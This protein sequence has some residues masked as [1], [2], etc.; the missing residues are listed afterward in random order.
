MMAAVGF[1]AAGAAHAQTMTAGFYSSTGTV[2]SNNGNSNCS[3]IGLVPG[4]ANDSVL[5]FPGD[6]N[7]GLTIYVPLSG[8]E[9]LCNSF[10]NV[11]SGG[12]NN[13]NATS[14]CV[15]YTANGAIPTAGVQFSFTSI[16]VDNYSAIGTTTVTIPANAPIGGGCSA[17][18]DTTTVYSGD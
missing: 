16:V 15:I 12:L 6:G 1:F 17:V 5:N 13:F 11:P 10:P 14:N 4:A 2:A 7:A 18:V 3:A 9:Q 8:T